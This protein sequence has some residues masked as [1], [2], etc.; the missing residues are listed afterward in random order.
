MF[1]KVTVT[2]AMKLGFCKL[3]LTGNKEVQKI[4]P[5]VMSDKSDQEPVLKFLPCG[6]LLSARRYNYGGGSDMDVV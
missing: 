3:K 2:V 6:F 5:Y 4:V 1:L